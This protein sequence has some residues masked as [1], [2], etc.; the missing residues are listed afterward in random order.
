[1]RDLKN[2]LTTGKNTKGISNK[3]SKSFGYQILGFGSGSG[4]ALVA[5]DYLV[6]AGGSTGGKRHGGGGGA[7][8]HRTSYPGG[9]QIEFESGVAITVGAGGTH[10][11]SRPTGGNNTGT[12]SVID[13]L[14]T[15][16]RGGGGIGYGAPQTN[17]PGYFNGG[18]GGGAGHGGP[19]ATGGSGNTPPF[20]PPQGNDGG[21]APSLNGGGGGGANSAGS[22]NGGNGGT[23]SANAIT[24]S[25]A[26]RAGGGG[27]A[28][29]IS[30]GSGSGGGGGAQSGRPGG[31]N[32]NAATANTGSGS[33]GTGGSAPPESE[34]TPGN[35]GSGVVVIRVP[36][37]NDPGTLSIA[38]GT[39]SISD[40][41]GDK[42]CTF[43]VSGTLSF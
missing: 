2:K 20:S 5:A 26:S 1:M 24:G 7:G 40:S 41:G 38:P 25:P 43:T 21:N 35:G 32:S 31:S 42:I 6:V 22:P 23:S 15:S 30:A 16:T 14:I 33:G 11:G 37:A 12:D 3:K 19:Q 10:P 8:G 4:K 9:T 29:F 28:G 39:N 27:G 18:S 34:G 36:A 13:G 17:Y